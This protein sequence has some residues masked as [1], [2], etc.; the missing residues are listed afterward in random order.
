MAK[1]PTPPP[2]AFGKPQD[3]G[4]G[5]QTPRVTDISAN[6]VQPKPSPGVKPPPPPPPPPK[7]Q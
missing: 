5:I 3:P 7:K 2:R 6:S 1:E 4:N